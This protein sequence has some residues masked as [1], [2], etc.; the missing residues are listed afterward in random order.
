MIYLIESL[1]N[2]QYKVICDWASINVQHPWSVH[3]PIKVEVLSNIFFSDRFLY[4]II[5]PYSFY[6]L[7][8]LSDCYRSALQVK[9]NA[10]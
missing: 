5:D 3:I 1:W 10:K 2:T 8:S 7:I 9:E 6:V 4:P